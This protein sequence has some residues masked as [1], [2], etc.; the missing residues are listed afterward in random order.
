MKH[1]VNYVTDLTPAA[2]L[3]ENT[4]K[5]LDGIVAAVN[6][7][8]DTPVVPA[9]EDKPAAPKKADKKAAKAKEPKK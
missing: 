9:S 4:R 6:L 8:I 1:V 7:L 2:K 3:K 5:T